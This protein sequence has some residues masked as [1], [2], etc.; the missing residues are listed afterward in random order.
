MEPLVLIF[1]KWR[2]LGLIKINGRRGKK[3]QRKL[4]KKKSFDNIR[5]VSKT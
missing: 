3:S 4:K 2:L 5:N 1:T